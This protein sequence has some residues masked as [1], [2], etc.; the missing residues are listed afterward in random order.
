MRMKNLYP[1]LCF[2]LAIGLATNS[3]LGQAHVQTNTK[4]TGASATTISQT[5]ASSST[6]GNLIVVHLS[7]D[8][9]R[10]VKTLA[11]SKGNSYQQI[12]GPTNW[13]TNSRSE[14]WYAY[15][16]T[17]GGGAITV[18]ATLNNNS[19]SYLQIYISEFSGVSIT[20]PLDQRSVLAGSTAA[21][22]SGSETTVTSNEIIYGV[23][24]GAS[25]LLTKG[26]G[27]TA[28]STANQNVVEMK[29][30]ASTGSYSA[31]FTSAGG[32]WVAEMATF[33]PKVILPVELAGFDAS[34]LNPHAVK[35][36]W[37]TDLETNNNY[38]QVEHSRDGLD[39]ETAKT[40]K[41]AGNSNLPTHYSTI[42][43]F[44]FAGLS[45]YRLKQV[46]LDGKARYSTEVAVTLAS[47]PVPARTVKAY[48]NPATSYLIVEEKELDPATIF[49]YNSIGQ[50]MRTAITRVDGSR[51]Q[52]DLSLLPKGVY[53]LKT[54]DKTV[55]FYRQ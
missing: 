51:V 39:W 28:L 27:F 10:H 1:T 41:G 14:L 12:N 13:S 18:T 25:G 54:K 49:V 42:D 22:N 33:K 34:V 47:D 37:T 21:V 15:N 30:G 38:F 52:V 35:I 19:T 48:P 3:V 50:G 46:D 8:G 53:F 5:F 32:D 29:I 44:P 17:G 11:D 2:A 4:Y 36:D 45:Y 6:T 24:I 23:S 43:S 26:A 40:V 9:N 55:E 16:I 20:D 7:F 31:A